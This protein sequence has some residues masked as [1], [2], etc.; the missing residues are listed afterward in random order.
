MKKSSAKYLLYDDVTHNQQLSLYR[1]FFTLTVK[2]IPHPLNKITPAIKEIS[3][4]DHS[5]NVLTIVTI[6]TN[7]T[8]YDRK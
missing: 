3:V 2:R 1:I 5:E 7:H 6:L 4:V 8:D